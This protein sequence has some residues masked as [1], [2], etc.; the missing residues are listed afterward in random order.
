[1]KLPRAPRSKTPRNM[2]GW[3]VELA[4]NIGRPR[5]SRLNIR[6]NT[7]ILLALILLCVLSAICQ[8]KKQR[9]ADHILTERN[10]IVRLFF[11]PAD[12]SYFHSALLFRV[13]NDDDPRL[14][15]AP[16]FKDGRTAYIALPEMHLLMNTLTNLKLDWRRSQSVARPPTV[17]DYVIRDKMDITIY[18]ATGTEDALL[19]PQSICSTLEPLDSALKTPRALWEFQFFRSQYHCQI[20]GFKPGAYP[21]RDFVNK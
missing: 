5:M 8:E 14:N 11:Q 15:T 10:T 3:V 4:P 9:E 7:W 21:Q 20:H 1:M 18:S 19:D 12:G 6:F 17:D 13:T 16:I 2:P